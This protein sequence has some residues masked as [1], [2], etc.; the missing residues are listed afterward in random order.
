M[1]GGPVAAGGGIGG[2][3]TPNNPWPG[4]FM[5]AFAAFGGILF[6]YDTGTISGLQQMPNWLETFGHPVPVSKTFPDGYGI[7][8][9]QRSLIV[10]ILSAGT[11]FGALLA[12]PFADILGRKWGT[13]ASCLVFSVGVALQTAAT[14]IPLFVVG[15]VFCRSRRWF[16]LHFGSNVSVRV[17]PQ[18]DSWC[19]R[20]S[21]P[22]GYHHWAPPL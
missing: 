1:P 7:T 8:S 6:G 12:A 20:R 14:A 10:S 18:V 22:V 19:C 15:R 21:L 13:V 16:S 9:S 17:L 11:F 2:N 3:S 4:I 5:A